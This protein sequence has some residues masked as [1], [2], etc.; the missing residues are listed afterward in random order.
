M[1]WRPSNLTDLTRKDAAHVVNQLFRETN[2]R[3]DDITKAQR[4]SLRGQAALN[5]GSVASQSCVER[6]VNLIGVNQNH[7]PHVAPVTAIGANL[8][9]SSYVLASDTVAIRVCNPTSSPITANTINW[10]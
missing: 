2:G 4:I 5:F 1:A 6:P 10:R 3:I 7:V 8:N 9:W